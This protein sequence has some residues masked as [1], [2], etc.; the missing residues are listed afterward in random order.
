MIYAS[1]PENTKRSSSMALDK[2]RDNLFARIVNTSMVQVLE[3]SVDIRSMGKMIVDH[4]LCDGYFQSSNFATDNN[5]DANV[6]QKA[7]NHLVSINILRYQ[8]NGTAVFHSRLVKWAAENKK[9]QFCE[10]VKSA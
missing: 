2:I 4:I 8:S 9:L 3:E 5:L 1:L 7:L 10:K 6:V